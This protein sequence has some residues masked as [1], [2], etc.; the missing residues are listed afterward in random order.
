MGKV[1]RMLAGDV[2]EFNAFYEAY[3][4]RVYR[5]CLR[6]V[7]NEEIA[8]DITQQTLENVLRYMATYKGEASFYTWVCQIC[9]NQISA[10]F[11]K[12][13]NNAS[14]HLSLDNNPEAVALLEMAMRGESLSS[15]ERLEIAQLVQMTLDALPPQYSEVLQMMYLEGLS[16]EEIGNRISKSILATQS[17]LARARGA[18]KI[19]INELML[20]EDTTGV[21][22]TS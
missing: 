22:N 20:D 13:G 21:G 16:T 7:K 1:R 2:A 19:V 11:R 15:D 10:W 4:D 12:E 14:V 17:L 8:S 3:Y 9:I 6:R 18:F 5:F